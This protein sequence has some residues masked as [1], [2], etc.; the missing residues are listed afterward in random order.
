M[1]TMWHV[2]HVSWAKASMIVPPAGL[3][4]QA[5]SGVRAGAGVTTGAFNLA[6]A[7][8]AKLGT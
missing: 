7:G 8:L 4:W 1:N 2:S 3:V 6:Q 5:K